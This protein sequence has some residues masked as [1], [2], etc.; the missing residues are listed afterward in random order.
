[1]A[2]FILKNIFFLVGGRNWACQFSDL[3][4]TYSAEMLDR[5][6][7]CDDTRRMVAGLKDFNG[8]LTGFWASSTDSTGN[9]SNGA[10]PADV[11]FDNYWFSQ[12][13][14]NT[15][16]TPFAFGQTNATG[17]VA[18]FG[19]SIQGS[20]NLNGN[21]G[22]LGQVDVE[23]SP[24]AG[25]LVRGT[26]VYSA[27]TSAASTN[28]PA[29]S[30]GSLTSTQKLCGGLFV[31]GSTDGTLDVVIT[32]STAAGDFSASTTRITFAQQTSTGAE[33]ATVQG[34]IT[35]TAFRAELT[36]GSSPS[37]NAFVA[38]GKA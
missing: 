15:T 27:L 35:D 10:P 7:L 11:D 18:F 24:S 38:V 3:N 22:E 26:V 21:V 25:P 23:F 2:E 28:G 31:L 20:Y 9:Y 17:N 19:E 36:G 16:G 37:F 13:Q 34:P 29:Y 12:I 33:F 4:F 5:T 30:L 32:S 1:M 6:A 14:P 8:Q